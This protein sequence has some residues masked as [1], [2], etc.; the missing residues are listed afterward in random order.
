MDEMVR[1]AYLISSSTPQRIE[2]VLTEPQE[3]DG[4]LSNPSPTGRMQDIEQRDKG[5]QNGST[6]RS[7]GSRGQMSSASG[8]FQRG[9]SGYGA[10]CQSAAYVQGVCKGGCNDAQGS[11]DHRVPM[12]PRSRD[13]TASTWPHTISS[14]SSIVRFASTATHLS[15][16]CLVLISFSIS[17]NCALTRVCISCVS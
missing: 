1:L 7:D 14:T 15:A 9:V 5:W 12:S 17:A 8:S 11:H 10:N 16:P 6:E 2:H 3:G 13:K 4:E